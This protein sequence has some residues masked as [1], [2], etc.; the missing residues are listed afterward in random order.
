MHCKWMRRPR[1]NPCPRG[2]GFKT[3]IGAGEG[4]RTLDFHLGKV[5][6]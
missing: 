3:G 2:E 5:A 6:F 1:K 4:I